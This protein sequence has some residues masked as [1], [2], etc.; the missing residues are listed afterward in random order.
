M[1]AARAAAAP[2]PPTARGR[3]D[4]RQAILSAAIEV[5]ARDGYERAGVEA[6]AAEAGVAKPTIYNHLGGKEN[7]YRAAMAEAAARSKTKVLAAVDGFPTTG[8]DLRAG[9]RTVARSLVD[10]HISP[11]G[12][13][14]S[15]LLYTEAARFPEVYDEV[16]TEGGR[17]INEA[18]AGRLAR[19]GNAGVLRVP[20]PVLAAR[21]FMALITGELAARTAMGTR[22]LPE[23]ELAGIIADGVETFL[24][25]FG[26]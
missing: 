1:S 22:E 20:D 17:Q 5:F 23:E 6:I 7:L 16:Q 8:E 12:W 21:H 18:L 19:L 15:R 26:T 2:A 9:L 14:L 24:A 4:K 13:A 10:C 25:A 3:I 11:Q